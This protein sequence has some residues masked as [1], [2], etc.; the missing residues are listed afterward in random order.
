M[1]GAF[2]VDCT[3]VLDDTGL[4]EE[5]SR[6]Y[7]H[8]VAAAEITHRPRVAKTLGQRQAA[9]CYAQEGRG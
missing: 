3:N 5:T 8:E 9:G 6:L 1:Q 7:H 4:D 2:N